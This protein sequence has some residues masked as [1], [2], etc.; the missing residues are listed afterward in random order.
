MHLFQIFMR[1][2]RNFQIRVFDFLIF[3][4][5]FLLC[6]YK[7]IFIRFQVLMNVVVLALLTILQYYDDEGSGASTTRRPQHL[8]CLEKLFKVILG[9]FKVIWH[10]NYSSK[11]FLYQYLC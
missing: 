1:R 6:F 5:H 9:I 4:R 10:L 7:I 3:Q 2:G 11:F 8:V